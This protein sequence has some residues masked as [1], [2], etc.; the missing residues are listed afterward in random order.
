MKFIFGHIEKKIQTRKRMENMTYRKLENSVQLVYDLRQNIQYTR[1]KSYS[2][3]FNR[4]FVFC[5]V[6]H[7]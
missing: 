1:I 2:F 4:Y 6:S 3:P 7:Y 5:A